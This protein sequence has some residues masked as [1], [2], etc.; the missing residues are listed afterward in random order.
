M[1]PAGPQAVD[2]SASVDDAGGAVLVVDP[3][4]VVEQVVDLL[5]LLVLAADAATG[6]RPGTGGARRGTACTGRP[7]AAGASGSGP[8]TCA[9]RSSRAAAG[10]STRSACSAR[11]RSAA[12]GRSAGS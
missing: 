1:L 9:S 2:G 10:P 5:V 3:V 7:S 11:A 4:L 12:D 8:S 6:P